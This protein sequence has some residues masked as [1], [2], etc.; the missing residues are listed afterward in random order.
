[1]DDRWSNKCRQRYNYSLNY[2]SGLSWMTDV[3]INVD[4]DITTHWVTDWAYDG[5]LRDRAINVDTW[6]L[7]KV[8]VKLMDDWGVWCMRQAYHGWLWDRPIKCRHMI[9]LWGMHQAYHGWL[10]DRPINVDTWLL[11]KVC[12][13]LMDDWGVWC[14]RQAYH[15]WLR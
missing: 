8:C 10:W 11:S 4:R 1:M 2:E 15:G 5:W 14:M 3:A 13:K 7:S 9:T 6:L 12:V